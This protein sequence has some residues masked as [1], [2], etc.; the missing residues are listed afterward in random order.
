MHLHLGA[1][2]VRRP[3]V[4]DRQRPR[5]DFGE[6]TLTLSSKLDE[7]KVRRATT[8]NFVITS[9]ASTD[10]LFAAAADGV[11]GGCPCEFTGDDSVDSLDL[12]QFLDFWFQGAPESDYNNDGSFA[13]DVLDL[14][15]YLACWFPASS[16][17][18][19]P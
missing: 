9:D 16:G 3:V 7:Q 5:G 8:G 13:S 14:L 17:T 18:P 12:L 4:G 1:D 11:T 10:G 6:L 2:V 15:D 19:C